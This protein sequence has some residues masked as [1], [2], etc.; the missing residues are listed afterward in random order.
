MEGKEFEVSPDLVLPIDVVTE[1]IAVLGRRGSGKTHT[2]SKIVEGVLDLGQQV[3]IVDPLDVWHG[4]RSSADGQGDGYPVVVFGGTHADVPIEGAEGKRLADAI[5]DTRVSA[6]VS[7]RHVSKG[8]AR[9]FVGDFAER[10]YERKGAQ[11]HREPLLLVVDE[12]DAFVPQ[13]PTPDG[14]KAYGAIDT[15]VRRGRSSGFGTML[16]S[17]RAA[18]LAKDVLTQTEILV[19]HQ[20]TG[21][22]DR[23]A[24]EVWV[25]Q[26][27]DSEN[28]KVFMDSLKS[29][30]TGEAWFWSPALLNLFRRVQV[31]PRKTFDS[32]NTPKVGTKVVTPKKLAAVDLAGLRE[33]LASEPEDPDQAKPNG[34]AALKAAGSEALLKE[35]VKLRDENQRLKEELAECAEAKLVLDRARAAL[36]MK[37]FSGVVT[38]LADPVRWQER[39]QELEQEPDPVVQVMRSEP[40]PVANRRPKAVLMVAADGPGMTPGETKILTACIQEGGCDRGQLTVLTG[41]K[42][43]TRDAYIHRLKQRGLLEACGSTDELRATGRGKAAL[44]DIQPLPVGKELLAHWLRELPS[45]EAAILRALSKVR[46]A[47]RGNIELVTGFKRSTRDAYIHRLKTRRLISEEGSALMI[48]EMLK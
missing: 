32:S 19:C 7:L 24:L 46:S 42:R 33:L 34:K 5:V 13:R 16:I 14:T 21:P 40:R 6:I 45:G 35:L 39:K 12:A 25:D 41:Y 9:R 4:L 48:S 11:E 15:V 44:P 3:V 20:T 1:T 37:P 26:A 18:V 29:L 47:S 10:L 8:A 36:G 17:Q 2:G 23:K 22:Q 30:K 38:E 31:S 27:D 28:R 43:S